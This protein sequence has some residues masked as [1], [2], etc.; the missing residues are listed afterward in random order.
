MNT[1]YDRQGEREN[2]V[3]PES[4]KE[5]S[6]FYFDNTQTFN[7]QIIFIIRLDNISIPGE[8][9]DE[10]SFYQNLVAYLSAWCAWLECLGQ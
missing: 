7:N 3:D 2:N 6:S 9:G 5:I 1:Q 8:V 4:N 10:M